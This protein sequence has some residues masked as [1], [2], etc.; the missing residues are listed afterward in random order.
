MAAAAITIARGRGKAWFMFTARLFAAAGA[1][2]E[3]RQPGAR[4]LHCERIG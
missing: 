1:L 4:L 3:A 2:I